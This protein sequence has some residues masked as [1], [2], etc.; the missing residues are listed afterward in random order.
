MFYMYVC[1]YFSCFLG[2]SLI[3]QEVVIFVPNPWDQAAVF[4]VQGYP[5]G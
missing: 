4:K 5:R 2:D 3:L 1:M